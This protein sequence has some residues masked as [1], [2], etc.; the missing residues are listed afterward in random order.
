MQAPLLCIV[1]DTPYNLAAQEACTRVILPM[2]PQTKGRYFL[3]RT[4]GVSYVVSYAQKSF[5]MIYGASLELVFDGLL[6]LVLVITL[7]I[8][9]E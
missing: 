3:F 8:L 9:F 1:L 4:T 2:R 6:S 5:Q 7:V